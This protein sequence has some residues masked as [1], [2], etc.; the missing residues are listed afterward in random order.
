VK[1]EITIRPARLTDLAA[2]D[3]IQAASPEAAKW[4][5]ADY[6]KHDC[7]VCELNS[8]V[9]GFL[10]TRQV[11]P[12]ESE[13]LNI[14]VDP[15]ERRTGIARRLLT[16]ALARVKGTWFLEVR[17][18]NAAAIHLYESVGFVRAGERK[19]YYYEPPDDAIVMRFFS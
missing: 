3:A 13:I 6:L 18:S 11:A 1:R 19:N 5:P 12:G 17:A 4:N 9:A 14:A 15:A 10:V 16:D 2:I 7:R 8:C